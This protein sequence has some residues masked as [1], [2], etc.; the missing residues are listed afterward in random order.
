MTPLSLPEPGIQEPSR[1]ARPALRWGIVLAV[2]AG[3]AAM[4]ATQTRLYFEMWEHHHGWAQAWLRV[5]PFWGI[6]ALY[7]PLVAGMAVRFPVERG[8]LLRSL[9]PHLAA[10]V[11]LAVLHAY[12]YTGIAFRTGWPAEYDYTYP[13][14]LTKQVTGKLHVQVMIYAMVAGVVH[15]LEYYRRFRERELAATELQAR[16]AEA[17]LQALRTQLHPHF[18]FNALNSVAVL[19]LKGDT[20]CA[21]RMVTRLSDLLRATLERSAEQEIPLAEELAVLEK[22]LDIEQVRFADRLTVRVEA[23]A[24]VLDALVP[25]LVLQPL[26]ENA[27]RHGIAETPGPGRVVVRA[28]VIASGRLRLEVTDSGPGLPPGGIVREGIGVSNTRA[29]LSRLYGAAARFTLDDAPEGGTR[30]V[31]EMPLRLRPGSLRV[32]REEAGVA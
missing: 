20:Q 5:A 29:R 10:A 17:H 6:W 13:V 18:L 7:T 22:Y 31:V 25:A 24:E 19:A 27:I 30:A 28:G 8:T 11:G 2:W 1:P 4:D 23:E 16:L 3:M 12:L 15:A 14:L 21:V 26:A 9:P 32:E